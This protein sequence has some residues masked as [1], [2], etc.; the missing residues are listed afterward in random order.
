MLYY[1]TVDIKNIDALANKSVSVTNAFTAYILVI[2]GMQIK[3][4][5]L[6]I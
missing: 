5:T 3:S 1:V 2:I 4:K 6:N